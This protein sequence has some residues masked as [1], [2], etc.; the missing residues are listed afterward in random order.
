[1]RPNRVGAANTLAFPALVQLQVL[2][3]SDGQPH[4]H[5]LHRD[6]QLTIQLQESLPSIDEVVNAEMERR[7]MEAVRKV[8][9]CSDLCTPPF[10]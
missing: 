5:I 10:P 4:N 6:G 1:M 8:P 9:T 7:R 2:A 3:H